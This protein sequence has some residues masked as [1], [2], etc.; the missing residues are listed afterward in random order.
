MSA[1]EKVLY[2]AKTHTTGEPDGAAHSSDGRPEVTPSSPG[3]AVTGF[4]TE[5]LIPNRFEGLLFE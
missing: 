4:N 5:Y 2:T 3:T 1:I